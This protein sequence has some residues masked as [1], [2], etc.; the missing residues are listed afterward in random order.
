MPA[1]TLDPNREVV[2]VCNLVS[3]AIHT[4]NSTELN[5]PRRDI[6]SLLTIKRRSE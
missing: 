5:V 2:S 1:F 4:Q 6:H 3:T